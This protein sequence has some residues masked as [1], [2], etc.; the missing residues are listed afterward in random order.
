VR[1][2]LLRVID[3]PEAP[4]RSTFGLVHACADPTAA[5]GCDRRAFPV[6]TTLMSLTAEVLAGDLMPPAPAEPPVAPAAPAPAAAPSQPVPA[7]PPSSPGAPAG[8]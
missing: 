5:D 1:L 4:Q 8:V 6:R 3:T 7:A 2:G